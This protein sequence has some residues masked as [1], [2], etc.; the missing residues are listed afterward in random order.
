MSIN[1]IKPPAA[2]DPVTNP[3]TP[4]DKSHHT[5]GENLPHRDTIT[6]SSQS[7]FMPGAEGVRVGPKV[8]GNGSRAMA[9]G[10]LIYIGPPE[11]PFE[12]VRER[13]KLYHENRDSPLMKSFRKDTVEFYEMNKLLGTSEQEIGQQLMA[14]YED[15]H[16]RLAGLEANKKFA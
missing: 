6:I 8:E 13:M 4:A 12:E 10:E 3:Q 9:Y 14:M 11:M 15:L 5:S 2:Y 7:K 16:T 1:A